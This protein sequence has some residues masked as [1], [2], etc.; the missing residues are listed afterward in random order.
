MTLQNLLSDL[1]PM[2]NLHPLTPCNVEAVD[3]NGRTVT[4]IPEGEDENIIAD[5]ESD[6]ADL[7]KQLKASEEENAELTRQ[8]EK[9]DADLDGGD[10]F[11]LKQAEESAER[12]RKAASDWAVEVQSMRDEVTALRK[13]KGIMPGFISQ[14][15]KIMDLL[16]GIGR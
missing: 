13:K 1:E 11:D 12:F 8:L 9:A 5:L 2:R 4:V 15:Q 16:Y 10:A 14:Q 6:N 3:F 7:E